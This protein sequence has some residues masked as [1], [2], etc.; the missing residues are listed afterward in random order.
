M[1]RAGQPLASLWP[2]QAGCQAGHPP[3]P[4]GLW[5][6]PGRGEAGQ[7]PEQTGLV[8]G[9][10]GAR[11]G[12]RAV[13]P[14]AEGDQIDGESERERAR[15]RAKRERSSPR[16]RGV[17]RHGAGVGIAGIRSWRPAAEVDDDEDAHVDIGPPSS[18]LPVGWEQRMRRC[19]QWPSIWAARL[20]AVVERGGEQR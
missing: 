9:Q 3:E 4:A 11:P 20:Q 14:A 6:G 17:A 15:E 18:I 12:A 13:T 2:V 1:T 10:A 16:A 5:A 19:L 7:Q 8:A